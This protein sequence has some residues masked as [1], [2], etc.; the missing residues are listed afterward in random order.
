MVSKKLTILFVVAASLLS[1]MELHNKV[2]GQTSSAD[3]A[4]VLPFENTSAH[5][6]Y[7]WIGES[8]A[9][10][11]SSLLNK[12]GLRVI[13]SEERAVAYQRLRLP[14]SVLPSRATAIKIARELNATM[15]V[16]GTY[17]VILPPPP[18]D[19][20]KD[21]AAPLATIAGEAR[22]IRVDEGRMSGD[23][24]DG[25]WAPRAYDFGGT[26]E[27]LQSMHGQLAYQILFQ[28]DKALSFSRTQL[29]QEAT[30]V[31]P[32]AF[33]AYQKGM[34]T[35]ELEARREIYLRNALYLYGKENGGATYPQ[36]A[37]QLGRFYQGQGKW[38]EAAEYY[39][40]LQKKDPHY[41]EAQF[42]AG[43]A[44][45]KLGDLQRAVAELV[46][47]CNDM[48]LVGVYN[49]AGA[50]SIEAARVE[51]K[52]EERARLLTQA[53][54]L[55]SSAANSSPEDRMVQFNM[56]TSFSS[57]RSTRRLLISCKG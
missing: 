12:P 30:K 52:P 23:I 50:V 17:D 10:S 21:A 1:A 19:K 9:D 18:K 45:W 49:N 33:Q 6:E 20:P 3:V 5:P 25:A 37:F 43:L 39:S 47:L 44:H 7:N 35:P 53:I 57:R 48:P 42:Y 2:Q 41:G 16:I 15:L 54:N 38:K 29:I 55:L 32:L 27:T 11:L 26:I 22:V 8:F 14:L 34:Q 4:L 24:F 13:S 56:A 46:P 40:M 51:K 28:R 36:A 31:P